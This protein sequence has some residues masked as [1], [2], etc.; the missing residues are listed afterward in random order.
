MN[1]IHGLPTWT[2][3]FCKPL[4]SDGAV[5]VSGVSTTAKPTYR[6][7]WVPLS[8]MQAHRRKLQQAWE[9]VHYE[10]AQPI[11]IETEWRDVPFEN[12]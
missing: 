4:P 6:L 9:T 1:C 10:G 7:R 5:K 3:T 11:R 2:C 8:M 12:E